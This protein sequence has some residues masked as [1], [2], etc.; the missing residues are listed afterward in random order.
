MSE[1]EKITEGLYRIGGDYYA[2]GS[3]ADL[4]RNL[5]YIGP[6]EIAI[7]LSEEV[8]GMIRSQVAM[9]KVW[10]DSLV[11]INSKLQ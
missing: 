4:E 10:N 3:K 9:N 1:I 2:I 6:E 5:I 8:S 7:K 11:Y